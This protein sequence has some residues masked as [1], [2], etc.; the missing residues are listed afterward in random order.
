MFII[1]MVKIYI[2]HSKINL[3]IKYF[4]NNIVI[5]LN[6]IHY[7][8]CKRFRVTNSSIISLNHM[9]IQ[10]KESVDIDVKGNRL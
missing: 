8:H 9:K 6:S 4:I 1:N 3:Y 10:I 7:F 5:S 2:I